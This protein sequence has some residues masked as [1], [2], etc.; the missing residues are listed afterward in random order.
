LSLYRIK[1][2][3]EELNSTNR[4]RESTLHRMTATAIVMTVA[5]WLV[6]IGLLVLSQLPK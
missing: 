6:M 2:Y 1:E 4:R 3:V 5:A